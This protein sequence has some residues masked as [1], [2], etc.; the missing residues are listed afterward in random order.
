MRMTILRL[1]RN[2]TFP[3]SSPPSNIQQGRFWKNKEV[4]CREVS[5]FMEFKVMFCPHLWMTSNWKLTHL[6]IKY[7]LFFSLLQ[8]VW[9]ELNSHQSPHILCQTFTWLQL[10]FKSICQIKIKKKLQ[11]LC[12]LL[13]SSISGIDWG[14]RTESCVHFPLTSYDVTLPR[15]KGWINN[16]MDENLL[17]IFFFWVT[18]T[19]LYINLP[20]SFFHLMAVWWRAW[21]IQTIRGVHLK[22]TSLPIYRMEDHRTWV[23]R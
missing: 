10:T 22:A 20:T 4:L 13:D 2:R 21:S 14:I 9:P 18:N 19:G 15:Q 23:F 16:K 8:L 5:R 1:F 17:D 11:K 7:V 6:F 12:K 3:S